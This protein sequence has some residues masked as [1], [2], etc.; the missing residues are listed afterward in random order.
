MIVIAVAS[1]GTRRHIPNFHKLPVDYISRRQPEIIAHRRGNV[2]S[3]PV[4]EI[5]F[6]TFV[7]EDVLKM[8]GAKRAAI[9]PLRIAEAIPLRMAIQR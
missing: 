1:P 5:R 8:V 2:Q 3:R 6:R 4:V 9:L 7:S